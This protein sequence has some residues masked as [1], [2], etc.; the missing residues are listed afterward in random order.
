MPTS[1]PYMR[2]DCGYNRSS[3]APRSSDVYGAEHIAEGLRKPSCPSGVMVVPTTEDQWHR[4]GSS[5]TCVYEHHRRRNR[6]LR[7]TCCT[8]TAKC[9]EDGSGREGQCRG[10]LPARCY[11]RLLVGFCPFPCRVLLRPGVY[12]S[13]V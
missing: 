12:A 1:T 3:D 10:S 8:P 7:R 4:L 6:T 2:L 13:R 11:L 5:D 9:A